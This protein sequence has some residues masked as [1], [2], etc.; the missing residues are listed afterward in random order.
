MTIARKRH[1]SSL[2]VFCLGVI[3]LWA[4]PALGCG[5]ED[6]QR[7]ERQVRDEQVSYEDGLK[8]IRHWWDVLQR[9]YPAE[10]FDNRLFFPVKG[11]D[12]KHVG[13]RN[14]SG[15]R[16]S[17]YQF[18]GPTR[19]IGH[20]AQDIFVYDGNQDGLDDRTGKPVEILAVADGIVLSTYWEWTPE[21]SSNG[22]GN[23]NGKRGGNYV[24]IYHPALR[25]FAYYAHLQ[26][27]QVGLCERVAG[28]QVIATLG[29]TGTNAFPER[30]PTHLHLMLLRAQDMMPVNAYPF[31][32]Q[33]DRLKAEGF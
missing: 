11:Y 15:Y 13:G 12:L 10:R 16:P 23:G 8:E 20:P 31:L 22:N 32:A 1:H 3:L 24:W 33:V 6:W 14:G 30:S 26:D 27:I 5:E 17:R 9:V 28:G 21:L 18:V 19:R 25:L 29:R 7:F 2:C 4:L